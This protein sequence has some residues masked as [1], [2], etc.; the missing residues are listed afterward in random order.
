MFTFLTEV[1][2]LT[3]EQID[4]FRGLPGAQEVLPIV[5]ATLPR[6]AEGLASVDLPAL[7]AAITAPI[8]LMLGTASPDWAGD[9]TRAWTTCC[10]TPRSPRTLLG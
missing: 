4:G 2:G 5:A 8:L 6:E 10:R 7:A 1:V 9:I 3:R